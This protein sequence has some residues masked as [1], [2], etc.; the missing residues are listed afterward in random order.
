MQL[1]PKQLVNYIDNSGLGAE[2]K[3]I[4]QKFI[5][6]R[7]DHSLQLKE[8]LDPFSEE[9]FSIQKQIYE[10]ITD[11]KFKLD[12]PKKIETNSAHHVNFYNLAK[13]HVNPACGWSPFIVNRHLQALSNTINI[14]SSDDQIKYILDI[15]C[16]FG[17]TSEYLNYLG[18]DITSIDIGQNN[19][20]LIKHRNPDLK[21]FC[22]DIENDDFDLS[23]Y[24]LYLFMESLHH[25]QKPQKIIKK[26]FF[27]NPNCNIVLIGEPI[28]NYYKYWGIRLD[29]LSIYC[30]SKFGWFESGYNESYLSLLFNRN[31]IFLDKVI[32]NGH[33]GF[34]FL[35]SNKKISLEHQTS[36]V[37]NSSEKVHGMG[38]G[39][40]SPEK[41]L[42]WSSSLE[43][44]LFFNHSIIKNKFYINLTCIYDCSIKLYAN[45]MF[46]KE[47]F[48]KKNNSNIFEIYLNKNHLQ[49]INK[50]QIFCL[51]FCASK[52]LSPFDLNINIDKRNISFGI[53]KIDF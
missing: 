19:V 39:W 23:A 20:D 33:F 37:F 40:Y 7:F 53:I 18:F 50:L 3:Q 29:Y 10:K 14:L 8:N 51:K 34:F 36:H 24:D 1:T 27:S 43:S 26:I 15:G 52:L 42:T 41:N 13:N 46:L 28:I 22:I 47:I 21:T 12:N 48:L 35:G 9:Y 44:Y 25:I 16:G 49:L 31:N 4:Q 45:N 5:N 38:Y 6:Y 30:I 17:L 32:I 2:D 11:N